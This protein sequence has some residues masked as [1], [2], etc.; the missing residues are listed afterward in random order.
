MLGA[1][2]LRYNE[3][4]YVF[5][6][7][8]LNIFDNA[9]LYS[10]RNFVLCSTWPESYRQKK[11]VPFFAKKVGSAV[12]DGLQTSVGMTGNASLAVAGLVEGS[13]SPENTARRE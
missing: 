2:M 3:F 11:Q 1:A 9:F 12:S 5:P 7:I 6:E 8:T 13:D 10:S 4:G